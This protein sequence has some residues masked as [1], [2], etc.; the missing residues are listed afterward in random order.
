MLQ[1]ESAT[2]IIVEL[3]ELFSNFVSWV[4]ISVSFSHD[5]E[6]LIF[7]DGVRDVFVKLLHDVSDIT[8]VWFL[9]KSCHRHLQLSKVDLARAV[10]VEQ[11]KRVFYLL[12]VLR[13]DI[14]LLARLAQLC[15]AD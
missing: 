10:C 6:E 5:Y 13:R 8:V 4:S 9:P 3:F 7:I 2:V 14:V 11:V 15:F 1:V 12:F